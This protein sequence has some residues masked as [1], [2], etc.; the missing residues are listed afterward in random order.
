MQAASAVKLACSGLS[1]SSTVNP[2]KVL[3]DCPRCKSPSPDGKKYC[4]ECGT[5]LSL[6]LSE[7]VI[8]QHIQTREAPAMLRQENVKSEVTRHVIAQRVS[9][10]RRDRRLQPGRAQSTRRREL[11]PRLH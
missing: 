9:E 1:E 4:G 11:P 6:D 3:M 10:D 2:G 5:Q 8:P 7:S